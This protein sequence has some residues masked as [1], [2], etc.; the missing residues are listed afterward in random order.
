MEC[1]IKLNSVLL[2]TA[3][4]LTRK[5]AK[6]KASEAALIQLERQCYTIMVKNRFTSGDGTT[7][8]AST[9][10]IT[11]NTQLFHNW[12][13]RLFDPFMPQIF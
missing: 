8:N 3:S 2:S 11:G 1:A 10:E 6:D 12:G 13:D 9:L 7:V 4:G 5:D